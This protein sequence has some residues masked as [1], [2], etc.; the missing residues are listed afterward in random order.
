MSEPPAFDAGPTAV[1]DAKAIMR[2]LVSKGLQAGDRMPNA[3]ILAYVLD[4]GISGNR[5]S[6][7]LTYAGDQAWL[8]SRDKGLSELTKS[9]YRVGAA[10]A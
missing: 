6:E 2:M 8:E 9:G 5:R 4:L 3:L 7:A 1:A 10:N